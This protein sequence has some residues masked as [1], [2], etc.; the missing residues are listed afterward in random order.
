M[1]ITTVMPYTSLPTT[2]NSKE[3]FAKALELLK[4][5][6]RNLPFDTI[7][8][9]ASQFLPEDIIDGSKV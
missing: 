7:V 2:I 3:K 9:K 5:K 6:N 1:P 8:T 4:V